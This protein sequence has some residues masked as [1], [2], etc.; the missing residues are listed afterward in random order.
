MAESS[1]IDEMLAERDALLNEASGIVAAAS[2]DGRDLTAVED[3]RVLQLMKRVQTL[4]EE[5]AHLRRHQAAK[6]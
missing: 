6:T 3:S 5:L 4:D 1:Q 2:A